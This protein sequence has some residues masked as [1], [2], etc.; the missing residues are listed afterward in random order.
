MVLCSGRRGHIRSFIGAERALCP[1]WRGRQG[2]GAAGG[3][4]TAFQ[5][6]RIP[7]IVPPPYAGPHPTLPAR[8]GRVGA[9]KV[10]WGR[11][12]EAVPHE[13]V[14]HLRRWRHHLRIGRPRL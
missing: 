13:E 14:W 7:T 1:T 8:E 2:A 4:V 12:I 3:S 10:G 11:I 5:R 9:R 6:H